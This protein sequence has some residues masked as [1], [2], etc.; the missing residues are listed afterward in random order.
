[1]TKWIFVFYPLPSSWS[2]GVPRRF[3]VQKVKKPQIIHPRIICNVEVL[4]ALGWTQEQVGALPK[5][6]EELD[7]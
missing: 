7:A 5:E 2:W 1:M 4:L 6:D 3:G